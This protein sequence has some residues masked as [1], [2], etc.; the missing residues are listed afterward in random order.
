VEA[1]SVESGESSGPESGVPTRNEPHDP[2][3]TTTIP[4]VPADPLDAGVIGA[5][6]KPADPLGTTDHALSR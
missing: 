2:N 4:S 3:R 5:L 6:D 1:V